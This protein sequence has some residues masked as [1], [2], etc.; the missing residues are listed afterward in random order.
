MMRKLARVLIAPVAKDSVEKAEMKERLVQKAKADV[1][2]HKLGAGRK[3]DLYVFIA[4]N[5]LDTTGG[6]V[7]YKVDTKGGFGKVAAG[8]KE[9]GGP[10]GSFAHAGL[11]VVNEDGEVWR[12]SGPPYMSTTKKNFPFTTLRT[13]AL[14][15]AAS[16]MKQVT[17]PGERVDFETA[18]S[19][20]SWDAT[21]Q[22]NVDKVVEDAVTAGLGGADDAPWLITGCYEWKTPKVTE[23][24]GVHG[25]KAGV[26]GGRVNPVT[27]GLYEIS[28]TQPTL[29]VLRPKD[30]I[31]VV[32]DIRQDD[33][34]EVVNRANEL[35]PG[36]RAAI[37]Q[38]DP[39]KIY[40]AEPCTVITQEGKAMLDEI[41]K[42]AGKKPL[43]GG[44]LE[45]AALFEYLIGG[46]PTKKRTDIGVLRKRFRYD[47]AYRVLTD[48]GAAGTEIRLAR[49]ANA[50]WMNAAR[51][52]PEKTWQH[53]TMGLDEIL[54]AEGKLDQSKI[55]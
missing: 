13:Q 54:K 43:E 37:W 29:K 22:G 50:S 41:R 32:V 49:F 30:S 35:E 20:F 23:L 27:G 2:S 44:A 31:G 33:V 8:V 26:G 19:D 47:G 3:S 7:D 18:D 6:A 40:Y 46:I 48:H 14:D 55:C 5:V 42:R 51:H 34:N 36:A 38:K 16:Y 25:L 9:P 39:R 17:A 11:D 52:D 12:V 15:E 24:E 53:H 10:V 1:S 28:Q 21:R 45:G 4:G